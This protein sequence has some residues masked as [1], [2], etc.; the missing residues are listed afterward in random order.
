[1]SAHDDLVREL[2]RLRRGW[3][4][5]GRVL[6]ERTGPQL[7][8]LCGIAESDDDRRIQQK[9]RLW[10]QVAYAELPPELA[11]AIQVAYALDRVHQHH[12]LTARVESYA[13]EQSWGLRTAR[14]RID[15]ATRLVAQAALDRDTTGADGDPA[16]AAVVRLDATR[17]DSS[18]ADVVVL[19]IPVPPDRFDLLIRFEA[20]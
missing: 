16:L 20:V 8:R 10:L 11:R 14:R 19:R 6:R 3:G 4:L 5:Q 1:M 13:S 2:V 17:R 18:G 15:H 7:V 9:I 12:R